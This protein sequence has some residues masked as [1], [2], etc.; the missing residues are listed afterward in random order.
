MS[1]HLK[2]SYIVDS[3]LPTRDKD[4]IVSMWHN[5]SLGHVNTSEQSVAAPSEFHLF[6][7]LAPESRFQIWEYALQEP[8]TAHRT[9][10]NAKFSYSL[11]RRVPPVLQVCRETRMW[12][13]RETWEEEVPR[14]RYQLVRLQ[15]CQEGGIYLDWA[16]DGVHIYRGCRS[17]GLATSL[18]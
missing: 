17:P 13:I 3:T 7:M 9:W 11:R 5:M 1:F 8:E 2:T 15:E 12:F 4:D 18:M 6:S 16:K 14:G 10:N